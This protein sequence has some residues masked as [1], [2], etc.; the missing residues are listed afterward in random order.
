M[1]CAFQT[2]TLLVTEYFYN[3]CK[4]IVIMFANV[5]H[6]LN[7]RHFDLLTYLVLI[8]TQLHAYKGEHWSTEKLGA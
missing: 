2:C 5:M 6:L 1:Y 3:Y 8:R 4:S 7:G